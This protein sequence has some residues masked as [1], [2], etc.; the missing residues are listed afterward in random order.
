MDAGSVGVMDRRSYGYNW[1]QPTE[2]PRQPFLYW[3][4]EHLGAAP[5][6][7]SAAITSMRM[8]PTDGFVA[9]AIPFFAVGRPVE[10]GL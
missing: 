7:M 3:S 4:A 5:A 2:L 1:S 9:L 6:Q 8:Q 10:A